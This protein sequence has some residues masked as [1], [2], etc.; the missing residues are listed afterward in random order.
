MR[1]HVRAVGIAALVFAALAGWEASRLQAWSPFDGPGPGLVP[2]VLAVLIAVAALGVMAAP[3]DGALEGGDASPL[4]SR[5]FLAYGAAMLG[6]ALALPYAGFIV[7]GFAA[8]LLVLRVGEGRSW[9][10]SAGWAVI[11]V[12][13]VTLLFGTALGVPFPDGPAERMLAPLRLIRIG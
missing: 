9:A 1:G 6:V 13:A 12:V 2:Q 10:R 8:T 7:T 4:R 5:C 3:G 11:L